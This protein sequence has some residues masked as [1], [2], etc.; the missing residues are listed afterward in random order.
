MT[1]KKRLDLHTRKE[2]ANEVWRIFGLLSNLIS[3]AFDEEGV[4][5]RV[6]F[7]EK[8]ELDG[9]DIVY[10]NISDYQEYVETTKGSYQG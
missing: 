5:V 7:K 9:P 4:T 10:G 2:I 1:T 8:H 3:L 6:R